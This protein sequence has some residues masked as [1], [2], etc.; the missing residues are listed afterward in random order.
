MDPF[1]D[2]DEGEGEDELEENEKAADSR[3]LHVRGTI[4]SYA[5]LS[6]HPWFD[7]CME[8]VYAPRPR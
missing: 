6:A 2:V 7:L 4:R 1:V 5:R 3:A 8:S